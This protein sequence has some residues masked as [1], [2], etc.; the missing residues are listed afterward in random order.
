MFASE[1]TNEEMKNLILESIENTDLLVFLSPK[2]QEI[3]N[4]GVRVVSSVYYETV[5]SVMYS[6]L[7]SVISTYDSKEGIVQESFNYKDSKIK[8]HLYFSD[9][10]AILHLDESEC[11]GGIASVS[12]RIEVLEDTLNDLKRIRGLL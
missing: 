8:A 7:C 9:S 12:Q 1:K 5:L 6:T 10:V 2:L 11:V 3:E 4:N